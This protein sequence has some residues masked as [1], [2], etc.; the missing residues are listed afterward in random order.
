MPMLP[1][2]FFKTLLIVFLFPLC[3]LAQQPLVPLNQFHTLDKAYQVYQ[4]NSRF[5]TSSRPWLNSHIIKHNG[6]DHYD[7]L[8]KA[9]YFP[10]E[11]KAWLWRKLF[12]ENTVVV[13]KEELEL[14]I[15]PRVNFEFGRDLEDDSGENLYRN[16]RGFNL[17]GYIGKNFS[18]SSSFYENQGFFPAYLDSVITANGAVPGQGRA[19]R[20]NETGFDYALSSGYINY[21]PSE[22]WNFRFG[23]GK[24]F[25]GDG[26]RSLLLSDNS[27][28]YPYLQANVLLWD[29]R[30][31]YSTTYASLQSLDR[32]PR[33]S[34]PEASFQRKSASFHYLTFKPI[35]RIEIGL[36]EST[37]WQTWDSTGSRDFQPA[38]LN[39]VIFAQ[40]L[41]N[42][43]DEKNNS[44]LGLNLR[45]TATRNRIVYFQGMMDASDELGYQLGFKHFHLFGIDN[46]NFQVEYNTVDPF[47]YNNDLA[48]QN[49]SHYNQ[50]LAHPLGASFDEVLLFLNYRYKNFFTE[51]RYSSASYQEDLNG[52]NYGR[53]IFDNNTEGTNVD[54]PD[55][56]TLT[57][58]EFLLGYIFNPKNTMNVYFGLVNRNLETAFGPDETLIV[59]FG[60]RTSLTNYYYDF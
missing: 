51:M 47:A 15:D 56:R 53:N 32:V 1:H 17:H 41:F 11:R 18:F 59:R 24:N 31:Q 26:Y 4:P 57:Y 25:I 13:K 40:T 34:T 58:G 12:A 48:L 37:I 39:P 30:I 29:S 8:D 46:L 23:H 9:G 36:F 52:S 14:Y 44:L 43:L 28:N 2:P 19:K 3:G 55:D 7:A 60:F 45:W 5:H 50:P 35:P 38:Y 49:Y 20:F 6:R 27:F 33:A 21:S 10:K 16:T 22:N 42:G 54:G